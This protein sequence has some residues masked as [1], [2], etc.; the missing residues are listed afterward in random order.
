MRPCDHCGT[1][2]LMG[3]KRWGQQ[4]FCSEACLR[5][6]AVRSPALQLAQQVPDELVQ[7][8]IEAVHQ[9]DCPKCGREGPIDVHV[10]HR[11]WSAIHLTSWKSREHVSCRLCGIKSQLGDA[12]FSALLGWWGMPFGLAMTPIQIARNLVGIFRGPDPSKPSPRL[13][14]IVRQDI[15]RRAQI[16]HAQVNTEEKEAASHFNEAASRQTAT[17]S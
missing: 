12:L 7:R 2:I 13:E 8:Q 15:A 17:P 6:G 9:G 16:I 3:G 1:L 5:A 10:G 14:R 11:V 4:R